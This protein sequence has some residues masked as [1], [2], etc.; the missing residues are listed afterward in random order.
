MSYSVMFYAVDVPKLQAIYGSNDKALLE[1]ILKA[2]SEELDDN[3]DFFEDYDLEIDSR[4]ALRNIFEGTVS[5][6]DLSTAAMYGYV[7]KILCE[8]LGEFAGS[9]LYST[10]ILPIESKLMANGPPI[11][12]PDDTGDFPEIGFLTKEEI[13]AE[14]KAAADPLSVSSPQFFENMKKHTHHVLTADELMEELGAYR[15][16]LDE[17]ADRGL[18]T[19]AFRH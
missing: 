12:I 17:L 14:R 9:D 1:D 3:D 10:R 4:S 19:V 6:E 7:L 11:P 13:Q 8:H 16:I 18:G 5:R 15:D 2:Q